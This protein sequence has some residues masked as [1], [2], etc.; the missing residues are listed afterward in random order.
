MEPAL[1]P[2]PQGGNNSATS[3]GLARV[4]LIARH[5]GTLSFV[6]PLSTSSPSPSELAALEVVRQVPLD[7]GRPDNR[8]W[9]AKL[10]TK[11]FDDLWIQSPVSDDWVHM[12]LR[13]MSMD[14]RL[15]RVVWDGNYAAVVGRDRLRAQRK[16][17]TALRSRLQSLAQ[18]ILGAEKARDCLNVP[19]AWRI[20]DLQMGSV[21]GWIAEWL[22]LL[23][24]IFYI[25]DRWYDG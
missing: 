10:L 17:E 24:A 23:A 15:L 14:G 22:S 20:V 2:L 25:L 8:V 16:I 5:V 18:E 19:S 3:S 1:E 7:L 12:R 13:H 11:L 21:H 4:N 9:A 6:R